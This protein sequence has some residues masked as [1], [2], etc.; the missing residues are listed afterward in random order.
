MPAIQ[1]WAQAGEALVATASAAD[2]LRIAT[3]AARILALATSRTQNHHAPL[4]MNAST[5][6]AFL[7]PSFTPKWLYNHWKRLPPECV[8]RIGKKVLFRGEPLRAWACHS[9]ES[10]T[11]EPRA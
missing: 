1:H 2:L 11:K 3:A 6:A 10:V 5:A 4:L 7:G 9:G 8:L